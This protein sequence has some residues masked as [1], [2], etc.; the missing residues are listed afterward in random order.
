M[1]DERITTA[2]SGETTLFSSGIHFKNYIAPA[3]ALMALAVLFFS[4]AT[5]H[6]GIP[7]IAIAAALTRIPSLIP[8]HNVQAIFL[9]LEQIFTAIFMVHFATRIARLTSIRY[10]ITDRRLMRTVGW[11]TTNITQ[12]RLER[13][14]MVNI[15]QNVMEKLFRAG[16]VTVITT[17]GMIYLED[18][19]NVHLFAETINERLSQMDGICGNETTNIKDI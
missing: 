3:A 11:L 14:R 9:T 12:V 18:V 13:C 5:R 19:P 4:R 1:K 8:P 16:D 6:D 15:K 10:R 7:A 17:E 2:D